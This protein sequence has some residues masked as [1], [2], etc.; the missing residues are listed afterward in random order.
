M[1][2][3]DN[4]K[5]TNASSEK[6]KDQFH[7]TFFFVCCLI[8]GLGWWFGSANFDSSSSKGSTYNSQAER[9]K[10]AFPALLGLV[11]SSGFLFLID[12][13]IKKIK[14]QS[15]HEVSQRKHELEREI[16]SEYRYY[17]EMDFLA[18][19]YQRNNNDVPDASYED[20][21]E[22]IRGF[23][24]SRGGIKEKTKNYIKLRHSEIIEDV[25]EGL[26]KGLTEDKTK[27]APFYALAREACNHALKLD[28]STN[29]GWAKLFYYDIVLY[30]DAWLRCSVRYGFAIPIRPFVIP[31]KKSGEEVQLDGRPTDRYLGEEAIGYY[32]EEESYIKAIEYIRD[33]VLEDQAI[34]P[35]FRTEEARDMVKYYLG[36]LVDLL[37]AEKKER[38]FQNEHLL[39]VRESPDFS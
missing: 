1:E 13:Y 3:V 31:L 21:C 28:L 4:A 27:F 5:I 23:C 14:E 9:I 12:G 32:F 36:K 11:I 24:D 17:A 35:Y 22:R 30:L 8:F 26:D 34:L 39:Y 18:V 2:G 16:P 6:Y 38:A 7:L 20:F 29:V 10:I 25:L 37:T 15:D 33:K 19:Y